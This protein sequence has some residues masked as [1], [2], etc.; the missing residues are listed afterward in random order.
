MGLLDLLD[1]IQCVIILGGK[2]SRFVDESSDPKP[3]YLIYD[4]TWLSWQLTFVSQLG[5]KQVVLVLGYHSEAILEQHPFLKLNEF[6]AF[7]DM[8]ILT[9]INN[10]AQRGPF[11]SFKLGIEQTQADKILYFP[12]DVPALE[13]KD[14]QKLLTVSSSYEVT[15]C[16]FNDRGGHPL[17]LQGSFLKY[18]RTSELNGRQLNELIRSLDESKTCRL[19]TKNK[20]VLLNL[21]DPHLLNSYVINKTY[22]FQNTLNLSEKN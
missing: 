10:E 18:L 5:L 7:E 14:F 17:L 11:S 16:C 21:N 12:I 1:D 22:R 2:S 9:V 15:K 6:A 20:D 8:S 13:K 4:K 3:N 19:A